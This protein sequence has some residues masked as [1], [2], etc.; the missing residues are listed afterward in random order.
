MRA[1]L[2]GLVLTRAVEPGQVVGPGSGALFRIAEG[3]EMELLAMLAQDDLARVT[4]GTPAQV[5]P[6][7]SA[8]GLSGPGL[9]GRRRSSIRRPAR[10]RRGS[11]SPIIATCGRAASRRRRSTPARPTRRC[12]PN[13]AV[14][15]DDHG[16]FVY[17]V[18]AQNKVVR[19]PVKIGEVNDHGVSI[20]QG[21]DGNERVVLSAGAFL[22]PGQKVRPELARPTR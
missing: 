13:S 20:V 7:G 2:A 10:A 5:T 17:I 8:T 14:Q 11:R 12:C 19:R 9:A 6:V 15:S 18:D 1:P 22:N 16:N 4:V 3:G 21:L